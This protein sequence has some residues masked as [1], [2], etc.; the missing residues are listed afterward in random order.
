[1]LVKPLIRYYL[2]HFADNDELRLNNGSLHKHVLI[3]A[4]DIKKIFTKRLK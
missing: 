3:D 1:M 2:G 4:N